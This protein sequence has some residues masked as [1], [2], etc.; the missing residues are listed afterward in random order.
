MNGEDEIILA[1]SEIYY[2]LKE[3]YSYGPS[4]TNVRDHN[5]RL[6]KVPELH[7]LS[8]FVVIWHFFYQAI[9]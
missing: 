7:A 8:W 4:S 3:V 9:S 6:Y 5:L 1:F 2:I